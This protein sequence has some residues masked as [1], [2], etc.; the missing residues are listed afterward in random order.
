MPPPRKGYKA[1]SHRDVHYHWIMRNLRGVNE[2]VIIA[3]APVNGQPLVAELPRVVSQDMVTE[4][5][6]FG[7][8]NGWKPNESGEPLL[9]KHTRRGFRL[10]G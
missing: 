3:S 1:I 5:I 4:A 2:L 7:N 8:A 10:P 6:D 9:C